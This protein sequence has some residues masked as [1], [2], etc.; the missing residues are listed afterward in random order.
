MENHR[1]VFLETDR[2]KFDEIADGQKTIETRAATLKY[3]P[4]QAGDTLT[5]VCGSDALVKRVTNVSHFQSLDELF[6]SL[7]LENILPSAKSTEEAKNLYYK[8]PG[9]KDKIDAE[10]ILAFTLKS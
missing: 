2:D 1:L 8:F 3:R 9:Y 10:G 7:P 4:I 5:F 6:S